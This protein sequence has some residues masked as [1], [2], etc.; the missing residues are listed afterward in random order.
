MTKTSSVII[1]LF[2]LIAVLFLALPRAASTRPSADR[3]TAQQLVAIQKYIKEGWHTLTRSNA[4]LAKA[5]VDPKFHPQADNHWPVYVPRSEN[6]KRIE[7]TL[8]AQ[9]S[10]QDFARIEIRPLPADTR[11]VSEPGLLYLPYPYVVPGG[12]FNEMYGWDSYFIQV[13]LVRD[14]EIELAQNMVDNFL[15]EIQNYGRILNANRTYYLSRSQP[16]FL[17]Q[18]ILNVY[19]TKRDRKWL[20]NTVPAIEKYYSSWTSEPHMTQETGLSR[21]YDL[22]EGPAPEVLSDERD[23]QGRTHYDRVK[24]YYRTHEIKDYDVSQYYDKEKDQLTPLYYKG[25][26]S[27]R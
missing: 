18:M 7:Q 4:Q 9:M 15:Y 23:A 26:R 10:P 2:F 16:P 22:G 24:E 20:S 3:A 19:R 21:Y 1:C 11:E 25:D 14:G 12:R 5:A 13:G 27:M 17:T 6:L 8:R